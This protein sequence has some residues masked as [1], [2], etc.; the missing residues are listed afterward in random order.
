VT[1][2]GCISQS[3]VLIGRGF[4]FK[5]LKLDFLLFLSALALDELISH[6]VVESMPL[7]KWLEVAKPLDVFFIVTVIFIS[8]SDLILVLVETI[9]DSCTSNH[10]H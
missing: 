8:L 1:K 2:R 10:W 7:Q 9:A 5:Q 6:A 4:K 3:S